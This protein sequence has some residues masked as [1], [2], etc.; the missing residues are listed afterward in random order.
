MSAL[1]PFSPLSISKLRSIGLVSKPLIAIFFTMAFSFDVGAFTT[2]PRVWSA[3]STTYKTTNAFNNAQTGFS[4]SATNAVADWSGNTVFSYAY[5]ASSGNKI[6]YYVPGDPYQNALAVTYWYYTGPYRTSIEVVV[7]STKA[8]HDGIGGIG[9]G[10]FDLQSVLV[11]EIGHGLGLGHV[12][13]AAS[14]MEANFLAGEIRSV[15]DDEKNGARFL[16][17]P[18]Y[19]GHTSGNGMW[20]AQG[21][22]VYDDTNKNVGYTLSDWTQGYT[23][24]ANGGTL[25]WGNK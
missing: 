17:D 18:T 13:D 21:V 16:Y 4:Q 14:V 6:D 9:A 19:N 24:F 5:N 10:E 23:S 2:S 22:G 3:S 11:H 15:G 8:W 7:N 20:G 1:P 12:P 25:V